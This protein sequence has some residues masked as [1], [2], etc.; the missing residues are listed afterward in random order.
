M[1]WLLFLLCLVSFL[2]PARADQKTV[3]KLTIEGRESISTHYVQGRNMRWEGSQASDALGHRKATIFNFDRRSQ[4]VLDVEAKEYVESRG[5][6]FLSTLAMWIRRPPRVRDSG[7]IVDLHVETVDTGERRQIFGHTARH[8]LTRERHVAQAGAC[9][10]NSEVDTDGWY[11]SLQRG[12][13]RYEASLEAL[14]GHPCG[15]KIVVHGTKVAKGFPILETSTD[16]FAASAGSPAPLWSTTREVIEVSEEPLDQKLFE[17]PRDF[18]RVDSLPG[19][20]RMS[21]TERLDFEWNQLEHSLGS[22]FD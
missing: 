22:W 15:D 18:K 14:D 21:W 7:K 16:K 12:T 13:P 4:Y 3:T 2:L 5:P 8:L 19:G 10:G 9:S 1:R 11:V 17:P 20:P 6:D